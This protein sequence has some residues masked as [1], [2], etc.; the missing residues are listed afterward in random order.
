MARTYFYETSFELFGKTVLVSAEYT[1][2]GG[3]PAHMGSMT[4]AGHP[5][6]SPELEF[7]NVTINLTDKDHKMALAK[8]FFPAPDWLVTV[9]SEDSEIF[10]EICGMEEDDP[11]DD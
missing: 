10:A 7:S 3:C 5:A 9:I 2:T 8:N 1:L 6:E 11:Y 4:Y